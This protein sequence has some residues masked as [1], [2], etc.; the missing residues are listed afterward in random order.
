MSTA[1][2]V[3][4]LDASAL[5]AAANTRVAQVLEYGSPNEALLSRLHASMAACKAAQLAVSDAIQPVPPGRDRV[6]EITG[7]D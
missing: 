1:C 3:A 5:L 2:I 6:V 4:L 7:E